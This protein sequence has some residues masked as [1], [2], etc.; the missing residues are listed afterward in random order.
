MTKASHESLGDGGFVSPDICRDAP[1]INLHHRYGLGLAPSHWRSSHN[2]WDFRGTSILG[3]LKSFRVSDLDGTM[4][5]KSRHA[6][7]YVATLDLEGE[8]RPAW[9]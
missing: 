4:V 2:F 1:N 6:Q 3:R 7:F 5:L 9:G 8:I